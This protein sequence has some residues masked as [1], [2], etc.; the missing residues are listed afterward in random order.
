MQDADLQSLMRTKLKDKFS[1]RSY[2]NELL[3]II[4]G[5]IIFVCN[6]VQIFHGSIYSSPVHH[7][8]NFVQLNM[9]VF[10]IGLIFTLWL[11]NDNVGI[12]LTR[13]VG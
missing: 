5:I 7:K 8:C 3:S 2:T 12:D 1:Y 13:D 4:P 9:F 10:L 6:K 11:I